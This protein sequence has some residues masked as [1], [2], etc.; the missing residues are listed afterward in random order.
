MGTF[1]ELAGFQNWF[2]IRASDFLKQSASSC[3]F[4]LISKLLNVMSADSG[5]SAQMLAFVCCLNLPHCGASH[6]RVFSV[7][8]AVFLPC[9]RSNKTREKKTCFLQAMLACAGDRATLL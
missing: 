7:A 4:V 9:R 2:V 1:T 5:V 6:A 3:G 8:I